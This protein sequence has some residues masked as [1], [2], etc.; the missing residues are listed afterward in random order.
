MVV[1]WCV[2]IV[3][4]TVRSECN[5][6]YLEVRTKDIWE[7]SL[8]FF[9]ILLLK[10]KFVGLTIFSLELQYFLIPIAGEINIYSGQ[11]SLA[12]R[13]KC[14]T[15]VETAW[16]Q[17]RKMTFKYRLALQLSLASFVN[18]SHIISIRFYMVTH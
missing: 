10:T 15:R 18:N 3:E 4:E 5:L 12:W 8:I 1:I 7:W 13:L 9:S 2:G 14:F 16:F 6:M 17:M 11:V